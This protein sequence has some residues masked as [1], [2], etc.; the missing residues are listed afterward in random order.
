MQLI[1]L[2]RTILTFIINEPGILN[3]SVLWDMQPDFEDNNIN[4]ERM[5]YA[6][7]CN[8]HMH[9]CSTYMANK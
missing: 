4:T 8:M 7:S 1:W 9:F 3:L 5:Q 2:F 6:A